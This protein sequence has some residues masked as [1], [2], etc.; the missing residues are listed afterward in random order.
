MT[1]DIQTYKDA[2]SQFTSGV[3]IATTRADNADFGITLSSFI[4]VSLNPPMVAICVDERL[5]MCDAIKKAKCFAVNILTNNQKAL[6]ERFA[7]GNLSM[8]ER[9]EGVDTTTSETGAP[10]LPNTLSFID[11]TMHHAHLAG[12][13]TLFFGRVQASHVGAHHA[14]LVYHNRDWQL[15]R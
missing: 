8:N 5:A 11:C 3:T 2:M 6:A 7:D 15:L 4:S 14:P 12:D 13:H 9:F 10:I 1:A